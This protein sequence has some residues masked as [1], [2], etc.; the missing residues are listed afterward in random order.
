MPES[1]CL[2]DMVVKICNYVMCYYSC[3]VPMIWTRMIKEYHIMQAVAAQ[4]TK[5]LGSY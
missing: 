2:L 3:V 5:V 4:S 1:M